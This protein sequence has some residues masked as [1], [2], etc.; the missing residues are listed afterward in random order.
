M[1]IFLEHDMGRCARFCTA[2]WSCYPVFDRI[3][4]LD[5]IACLVD[6]TLY[7]DDMVPDERCQLILCPCDCH[8]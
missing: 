4:L 1:S 2:C 5:R 7:A 8:V 6:A 3:A